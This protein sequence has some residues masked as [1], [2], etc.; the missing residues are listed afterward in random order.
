[1]NRQK[2]GISIVRIVLLLLLFGACKKSKDGCLDV[3]AANYDP[4]ADNTCCCV[5]PKLTLETYF[6]TDTVTPRGDSLITFFYDKKYTTDSVQF[7]SIHKIKFYLSDF[8]LIRA[9][10]SVATVS[11][12]FH[13]GNSKD[14]FARKDI[15]LVSPDN[16]SFKSF[17]L[18]T[19]ADNGFFTTLQ[20]RVGLSDY[21]NQVDTTKFAANAVLGVQPD[22]MWNASKG[23]F[24]NKISFQRDTI[25]GIL[26]S[27]IIISKPHSALVSISFNKK[28]R[29]GYDITLK[30][31]INFKKWFQNVQFSTDDDLT[32]ANTIFSNTS[33]AFFVLP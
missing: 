15:L 11:D 6:K 8:Q 30:L 9:D 12:T 21:F 5:Y 3:G 13:I 26:P 17:S 32:V 24:F 16:Q 19:F 14:S 22:T 10:G 18:G 23:Y 29:V 33:S 27:Q 4:S 1:M 25:A 20:F 28:I 2:L 7:F 31:G